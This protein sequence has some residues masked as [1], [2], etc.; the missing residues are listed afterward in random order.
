MWHGG[1][2]WHVDT[3]GKW[4]HHSSSLVPFSFGSDQNTSS[5]PNQASYSCSLLGS[6]VLSLKP[7]LS[8]FRTLY[9]E[10]TELCCSNTVVICLWLKKLKWSSLS[11]LWHIFACSIIQAAWASV[12]PFM[13]LRF[14]A[15]RRVLQTRFHC[16]VTGFIL[17][18]NPVWQKAFVSYWK[19]PA[20]QATSLNGVWTRKYLLE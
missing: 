9:V 16:P 3:T 20:G 5:S 15:H 14:P 18:W 4:V 12:K 13:C 2:T 6:E 7:Q 10:T 17:W 1:R 11:L 19:N 8:V